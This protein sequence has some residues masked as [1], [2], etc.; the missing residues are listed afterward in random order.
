MSATSPEPSELAAGSADGPA[1][2]A[3]SPIRI[4]AALIEDG[5]R[6]LF[7]RKRGTE[8][9]MQAGGK[10]EAGETPLETLTRELCEEIGYELRP[11]EVTLI[12]HFTAPAVN[13]PGCQVEGA[14]YHLPLDRQAL[15]SGTLVLQPSG[16][17]AE[18]RWVTP[19]QARHLKLAPLSAQWLVPWAEKRFRLNSSPPQ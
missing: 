4:V 7:V 18:M 16:E 9:F 13:E 5:E 3:L 1:E 19:E 14:I 11:G 2:R 6:L 8:W 15:Q 10:A 17:I 12:D